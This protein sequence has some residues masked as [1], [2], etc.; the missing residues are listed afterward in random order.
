MGGQNPGANDRHAM[1]SA[2]FGLSLEDQN[3]MRVMAASAN[4]INSTAEEERLL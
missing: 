3:L 2:T 4:E 1:S